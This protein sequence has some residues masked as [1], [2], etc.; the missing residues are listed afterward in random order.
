MSDENIDGNDPQTEE[1]NDHVIKSFDCH[2]ILMMMKT[3]LK[4]KKQSNKG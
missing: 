3:Y 1:T 4:Q 2:R